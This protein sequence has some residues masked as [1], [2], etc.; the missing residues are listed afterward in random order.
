M[1][2]FTYVLPSD[3]ERLVRQAA[4]DGL[5]VALRLISV[6][7]RDSGLG[8]MALTPS[9]HVAWDEFVKWRNEWRANGGQGE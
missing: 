3:T 8:R 5:R 9:E 1:T 4:F 6:L 2:T 7:E